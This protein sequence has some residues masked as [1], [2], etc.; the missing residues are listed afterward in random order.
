MRPLSWRDAVRIVQSSPRILPAG[1]H[2]SY[3]DSS[4]APVML[5]MRGLNR[6]LDW[7]EEEN[8][9]TVEAGMRLRDALPW[10][11]ARKRFFLVTPG[12]KNI[13]F[14]GAVASNVHGKDHHERGSFIH[15]VERL[16]ILHADG[17]I[18]EYSRK[19]T[20][21]NH[22][23]ASYG[24]FGIIL[25]VTLRVQSI[26]GSRILAEHVKTRNLRETL[27]VLKRM[28]ER[29]PYTVAWVDTTAPPAE[30]GRGIVMGGKFISGWRSLKRQKRVPF[31]LPSFVMASRSVIRMLNA[32]Y[33]GSHASGRRVESVDD[34]FYPLD[35]LEGWNKVYG[36]GFFQYQF[37][38]P[39]EYAERGVGEALRL[40]AV[41]GL[42]SFVSVLKTTGVEKRR[43]VFDFTLPGVSFAM[44]IPLT[45][46]AVNFAREMDQLVLRYG[47]RVYVT[48]DS[49]LSPEVF[50]RMYARE[51]RLFARL[52][53]RY[54][55]DWK[56]VSD[57]AVRLGLA[58]REREDT[59]FEG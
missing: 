20:G 30:R 56:F 44:D 25:A 15:S 50:D 27:R 37:A 40:L 14:G 10:L 28:E 2:Y 51:K 38:I 42:G 17:S 41:Y 1:S 4:L 26:P 8:I 23:F 3:G 16:T 19:D 24:L 54:D 57:Q 9:L 55:P 46:R 45:P 32:A 48:K 5:D 13:T 7:D 58:P 12:T 21:F 36:R 52:K 53:K 18:R 35:S 29:L 6:F 11:L 43:G 47:G 33:Y 59:S 31:G 39:W 34:F 22:F 49:L